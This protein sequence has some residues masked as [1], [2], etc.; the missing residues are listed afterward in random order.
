[1]FPRKIFF[2][3]LLVVI[4][5]SCTNPN[6]IEIDLSQ[7]WKF[8]KGDN[9]EWANPEFNDSNWDNIDPSVYWEKQG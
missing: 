9:L 4:V 1:M 5:Y 8:K 6:Q 3:A 2:Y 7:S